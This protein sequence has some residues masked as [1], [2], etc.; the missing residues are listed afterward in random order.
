MSLLSTYRGHPCVPISYDLSPLQTSGLQSYH[1]LSCTETP[2]R[3]VSTKRG[4]RSDAPRLSRVSFIT[5]PWAPMCS[6]ILRRVA[7]TNKRVAILP[8]SIL[9]ED[10]PLGRLYRSKK[11]VILATVPVQTSCW[12]SGKRTLPST[13]TYRKQVYRR[14]TMASLQP[15]SHLS[16]TLPAP[17]AVTII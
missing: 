3:G 15:G 17:K 14:D 10:A 8:L 2:R 11:G 7:L 9:H 1:C 5:L 12:V 13:P 4:R 16:L 6:D